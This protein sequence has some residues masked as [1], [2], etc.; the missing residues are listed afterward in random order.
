MPAV[1]VDGSKVLPATRILSAADVAPGCTTT[2]V[3]TAGTA[4]RTIPLLPNAESSDP[5]ALYRTNAI[6][7]CPARTECPAAMIF[8]DCS[9]TASANS[10]SEGSILVAAEP[11]PLKLGSGWPVAVQRLTA[12]AVDGN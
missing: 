4:V 5:S 12:I 1:P 10:N 9:V 2:A 3:A 7:P 8:P 11:L 6:T